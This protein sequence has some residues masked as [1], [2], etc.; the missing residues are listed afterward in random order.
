MKGFEYR[1]DGGTP[2]DAGDVLTTPITGLSASTSYNFEVRK[3]SD[4]GSYSAWSAV[5]SG[6]TS[7]SGGGP[8]VISAS[9]DTYTYKSGASSFTKSYICPVSADCLVV[10]IFNTEGSSSKPTSVTY[11][12]TAMTE[13][14][15][16]N[17]VGYDEVTR[18]ILTT[19]NGLSSGTHD[20]VITYG[21][22][23][24]AGSVLIRPLSGV[25]QTTPTGTSATQTTGAA[26]TTISQSVSS[27]SGEL[28]LDAC[29]VSYT[30][31]ASYTMT[32]TAG[33]TQ[34]GT[35]ENGTGSN[36]YGRISGS[37]K[38]GAASVTTGWT[39]DS[40]GADYLQMVITPF[41]P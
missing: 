39:I 35:A 12:G 8:A 40:G 30:N 32:A 1:I 31:A 21:A 7:G 3:R 18:Y 9:I 28:V 20:I 15:N 23:Y 11:N 10:D 41:K 6:T 25:N 5:A 16:V 2:V 27:A 26:G 33:Q 29:G 14:V 37:Q 34:D 13:L 24:N 4:D 36:S 38:P 22:T 17:G 19:A